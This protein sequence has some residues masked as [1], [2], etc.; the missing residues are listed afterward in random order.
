MSV[1][2]TLLTISLV[3]LETLENLYYPGG[4]LR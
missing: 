4:D 3:L 1:D 2:H